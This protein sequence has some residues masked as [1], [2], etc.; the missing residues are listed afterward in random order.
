[1]N[2]QT[3]MWT[4]LPNGMDVPAVPGRL[5]LSVFLSVRLESDDPAMTTLAGYP[6]FL[7]WPGMIAGTQLA[8]AVAFEPGGPT[9][10]ADK[11]S[12]AS[13]AHWT[14]L[15]AA[16]A[17]VQPY[18]YEPH[19]SRAIRS[20]PVAHVTGFVKG[21]HQLA[22][23][24]APE[25]A[26]S[27]GRLMI[28]GLEEVTPD[29]LERLEPTIDAA[30]RNP[31]LRAMPA[32]GPNLPLDVAQAM[33]FH[34]RTRGPANF[35]LVQKPDIEFHQALGM[36]ASF[37]TLLRA[38]GLVVDIEVSTAGQ[39]AAIV[40]TQTV[41]LIPTWM[42]GP[43]LPTTMATP[44]T[45]FQLDLGRGLF[46]PASTA[47]NQ[48]IVDGYL[49]LRSHA[50][51]AHQIVQV[52]TDG[53]AL[54]VVNTAHSFQRERGAFKT[55]DAPQA[56]HL[57][58]LTSGG[59]AVVK[60]GRAFA[61]ARLLDGMALRNLQLLASPG[62]TQTLGIDDLRRGF[63]VDVFDLAAGRWFP[64][65]ARQGAA[66]ILDTGGVELVE[67]A[68][69]DEGFVET[70]ATE[71]A[72]S[73]DSA[74]DFYLHES[75]F[76]WAGWS[77]AAPRPGDTIR[78]DDSPGAP[79]DDLD[80]HF[81]LKTEFGPRPGSLPRLRFGRAYRLRARVV[82]LAGNSLP[83]G[84][85]A[86]MDFGRASPLE[87]YRRWEPVTYPVVALRSAP[88]TT[89]GEGLET[90]LIRS[91]FDEAADAYAAA[92]GIPHHAERHL[93]PP[94]TTQLMAETH[95]MFDL[96]AGL[97]PAAYP[98]IV[99]LDRSLA[100]VG[101]KVYFGD[102][103]PYVLHP[104]A[105]LE[106]PFLPDPLS[107]GA[108]LRGL[109]GQDPAAVLLIPWGGAWP[110]REPF[111][112]RV[113]EE[114]G[115]VQR[116]PEWDAAA[117]LLTVYLVKAAI[118]RVRL[119]S[120]LDDT[121]LD[122]LGPWSWRLESFPGGAA[123]P[124][125]RQAAREGR[126]VALT[127]LR[128][129]VLTHA[130]QQPLA[131]PQIVQI[132]TLKSEIGQTFAGLEGTIQVN[133]ASTVQLDLE[134]AWEEP[135]DD[136]SRPGPAIRQRQAQVLDLAVDV[137]D[138]E[139]T[140]ESHLAA[141]RH[142]LGDTKHRRIAYRGVATTRFKSHFP[143]TITADSANITRVGDPVE[144]DILNSARPTAPRVRYI[145]PTFRWEGGAVALTR[146]GGLRVYLDR[147]WYS[148]GAGELLGVLLEDR[149]PGGIIQ[150]GQKPPLV[151]EPMR[152]YVTQWG[153]D[154]I[155]KTPAPG[156]LTPDKFT[157]A[158]APLASDLSLEEFQLPDESYPDTNR[159]RVLGHAV[160]YD[161]VRRLWFCDI[162]VDHADSYWPFIR[163]GLA[164]YQP[165]SI[166]HAHLSRVTLADFMQLAPDRTA[167]VVAGGGGS[168]RLTVAGVDAPDTRQSLPNL[169]HTTIEALAEQRRKDAGSEDFETWTPVGGVQLAR[170]PDG[171]WN[172]DFALRGDP[173]M[174]YRL[175]IREYERFPETPGQPEPPGRLV[176][177]AI[178]PVPHVPR[179]TATPT[180]TAVP[181]RTPT[182]SATP[183]GIPTRT[184]APTGTAR[185][186]GTGPATATRTP[187]RTPST[188]QT[189]TATPSPTTDPERSPTPTPSQT[190]APGQSPTPTE[191]PQ[192]S[193]TPSPSPTD[194]LEGT[195][196]E[197]MGTPTSTPT[198]GT[199]TRTPTAEPTR[200][201]PT[202]TESADEDDTIYLPYT[203][204]S[205][206]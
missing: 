169:G 92:M 136:L 110:A 121:D 82:D 89:I 95:G 69:D 21:L 100:E 80:P 47:A 7:D 24:L 46:L 185:P 159:V 201:T 116:P 186:T 40:A 172:G 52:D 143:T 177:A 76:R 139:I 191:N 70:G 96:P 25:E 105:Q 43:A 84:D 57:P 42:P 174:D 166:E 94:R 155:W 9:V 30:L 93:A 205:R 193:P 85:P 35:V 59:L 195:P 133:G 125:F 68:I 153:L 11:V 101:D 196:T 126:H 60:A 154:P 183:T 162:D 108:A 67:D 124:A 17:P 135:I 178:M 54:K 176:Y 83:L 131:A 184:P 66:R 97:D 150:P 49:D 45:R 31:Q 58:S 61:L 102:K 87:T 44:R 164:R 130:V 146:K 119:S 157:H 190:G 13:S 182:A 71:D 72:G 98:Q 29:R 138:T 74:A 20:Y 168:F 158:A 194:R 37:P 5:R 41:R 8:F 27:I 144:A 173:E 123:P 203:R 81:R 12:V 90:L 152:P 55:A 113:V 26:P 62:E 142:E 75:L 148:S 204:K 48:E 91:N 106:I 122:L 117:R 151:R 118:A 180:A 56:D 147:P 198:R 175:V 23:Q 149:G 167:T 114:T 202:P 189:H 156:A 104:E 171:T 2:K 188:T 18:A 28:G 38:F 170:D 141:Y 65:C 22:Y 3:L 51:Q 64:L 127:P 36:L 161:P 181:T 160:S 33:R 115:E 103:D 88:D 14:A 111:R 73:E 77:L 19:T 4:A 192:A 199:S 16:G 128:T 120:F 197:D 163:L 10:L 109:P 179:P 134:A 1:M 137:T 107:R 112:L 32:A 200:R 86:S 50:G 140:L 53:A 165:K 15:F 78:P 99:A 132:D 187:T 129:L 39:L 34:K 145:V 206:T 6:D 79:D 63:R